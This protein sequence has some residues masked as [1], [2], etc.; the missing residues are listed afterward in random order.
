[1]TLGASRLR[2]WRGKRLMAEAARLCG[3]EPSTYWRIETGGRIPGRTIALR[4][5]RGTAGMVTVE[6]WDEPA[7]ASR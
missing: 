3:I 5:L 4:I 7:R 2:T 1:M 6:S